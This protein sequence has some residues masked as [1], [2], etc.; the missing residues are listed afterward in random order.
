MF[1]RLIV[2]FVLVISLPVA[3]QLS[4]S[5][6]RSIEKAQTLEQDAK[7]GEAIAVLEALSAERA[8]DK[9]F[10][11]RALGVFYWQYGNNDKAIVHIQRAVDSEQ[12]KDAQAWQ[13]KRML[14]DLLLIDGQYAS[15]L[16]YYYPLA[17]AIP[18]E[19]TD[20]SEDVWLRIMQ[21]HYQREQW[22]QVLNAYPA[23]QGVVKNG[24]SVS[25]LSLKLGAQLQLEQ[26]RGA[27]PTLKA[28]LKREPENKQWW[29]QLAANYVRLEQPKEA[30]ST[31]L[32]AQRKGVELEPSEQR[33]VAQLYANVGVPEQAA[34]WLKR[35]PEN[36]QDAQTLAQQASLWQQAREWPQ[37]VSAWQLAAQKDRQY[38]WQ[39]ALIQIQQ[40]DYQQALTSLDKA[41]KG[42]TAKEIALTKVRAYYKLKQFDQALKQARI[43]KKIAPDEAV[44][45]WLTF[46][47]KRQQMQRG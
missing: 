31:Y 33:T 39:L 1:K 44:E 11:N 24:A 38:H 23:Y 3:A 10:V 16:Q 20:Q 45:S 30:I 25:A 29:R 42:A 18:K 40:G 2:T 4:P 28:L 36:E 21:A 26:W 9:A 32:L 34:T 46:L 12:L 7:L 6:A 19:K 43:A 13:T 15:A 35:L 41:G 27:T 17:R 5:V 8:Y 47:K 14:A 37:A 22:S